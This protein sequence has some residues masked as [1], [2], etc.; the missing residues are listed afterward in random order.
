M[1]ETPEVHTEVGQVDRIEDSSGFP[2]FNPANFASQLLWLAICFGLFYLFI[3]RVAI[4]RIASIL[5]MRKDR[6]AADLAEAAR[7]KSETDA[8]IAAYEKALAIARQNAQAIAAETRATLTADVDAKRHA[9]ETALHAKLAS[10]E[11]EI[12]AVKL[13]ALAEVSG[14][15]RETAEAVVAALTTATV[16]SQEIAAAVDAALAG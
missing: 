6:I 4:P 16:S 15:A 10:A 9:A 1:A 8:A 2:P 14:I 13:K 5:D 12:E 3:G 7:L 11:A